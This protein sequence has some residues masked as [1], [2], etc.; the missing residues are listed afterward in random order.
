M[1]Q[2]VTKALIEIRATEGKLSPVM[3]EILKWLRE[4]GFDYSLPTREQVADEV[5]PKM[6]IQQHLAE[7]LREAENRGAR[8]ESL[9]EKLGQ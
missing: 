5:R 7:A 4:R 1:S 3:G 6:S 2:S 9:I 8:I